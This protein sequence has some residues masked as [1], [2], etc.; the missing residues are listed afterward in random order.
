[1][2][3]SLRLF[4]ISILILLF[5]G[6]VIA[7]QYTA[8]FQDYLTSLDQGQ[9]MVPAIIAM[10]DQVDLRSLQDQLYAINAD[11]QA[12]HEA[13]VLALQD[14][15]T[16]TQADIIARLEEMQRAGLVEKYQPYWIANVIV[17]S[18]T[19]TALDELARDRMSAK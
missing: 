3:K 17:V 8:D 11:R 6:P 1:M 15:A 13:V 4:S 14:M 5:S 12:W 10:S 9:A 19:R 16:R 7:G 2:Q 18:A